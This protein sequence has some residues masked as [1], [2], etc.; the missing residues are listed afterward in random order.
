MSSLG[1]AIAQ[2]K[3]T[4]YYLV[5]TLLDEFQTGSI[6]AITKFMG[7]VGYEVVSL[8]GQNRSDLQLNQVDD[9]INLE[10]RRRH[11]RRGRLRRD[12]GRHREDARRRH[13]G[14]DLRPADHLDAER[15]HL[16]RRHRRDRPHRRRRGGPAADREARLA[17][18]QG[19]A[20]PRRSGRPL[21]ARHPEGLRGEDGGPSGGHHHHPGGDAVGGRRNAGNIAPGPAPDQSRHRPDLHPRRASLGRGGRGARGR[22]ARSPARS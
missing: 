11:P 5:P 19:A 17:Q 14:D 3:G 21:H 13:P 7:D 18:G 6:D 9:V 10:A 1:S 2:T 15:P 12:Q 16:G 8:D 4:I 20:D 22:R